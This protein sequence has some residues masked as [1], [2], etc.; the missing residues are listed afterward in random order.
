M[1][2]MMLQTTEYIPLQRE[3]PLPMFIASIEC[4]VIYFTALT[5]YLAKT[6]CKIYL[7]TGT[8]VIGYSIMYLS[9]LIDDLLYMDFANPDENKIAINIMKSISLVLMNCIW[10]ALYFFVFQCERITLTLK[11]Q[12]H[13][14]LD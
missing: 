1:E 9:R 3:Y 11:A 2:K 13:V 12:N 10:V 5:V 4:F 7:R 14:H 8:L 6:K